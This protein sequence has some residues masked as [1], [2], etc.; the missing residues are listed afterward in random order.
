MAKYEKIGLIGLGVMGY[1]LGKNLLKAGYTVI[2]YDVFEK[3]I[4][5]FVEGMKT[6]VPGTEDKVIRAKNAA[7]ITNYTNVI[8]TMVPNSPNVEEAYYGEGG[9]VSEGK[10][11]DL[12]LIDMSSIS[13]VATQKFAKDLTARGIKFVEGPVSGGQSGALNGT[14][15]IMCGG[16]KEYIDDAMEIFEAV[17]SKIVNCGEAGAGQTVKVTNQLMSAINLISLSEAFTLCV[18]AGVDPQIA[19]DVITA[20]SGK[21]WA[22]DNRLPEIMKGN[23]EP[24]F[25]IDLHTKDIKLAVEMAKEYDI[26]LPVTDMVCNIFKTAQK[27]GLGGKDNCAVIKLYEELAGVEVRSK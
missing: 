21:C 23:F 4:D 8:V 2:V 19:M 10:T 15:T 14:L 13:P 17:G 3:S 25:K 12:F 22:L 11:D 20:G 7:D 6:D 27:K 26:P 5:R 18:K 24:G 16:P 9:I 1:G